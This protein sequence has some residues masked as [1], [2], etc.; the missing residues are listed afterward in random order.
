MNP[1]FS[2]LLAGLDVSSGVLAIVGAGAL[3]LAVGF[4][5]WLTDMIATW[6]DSHDDGDDEDEDAP[7]SRGL[8]FGVDHEAECSSCGWYTDDDDEAVTADC[9]GMCPK[10]GD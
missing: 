1:D 7:G 4:A 6:F 9:L 2:G 10:C 5:L 8:V 3:L